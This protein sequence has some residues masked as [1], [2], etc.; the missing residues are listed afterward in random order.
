MLE[1]NFPYFLRM[2]LKTESSDIQNVI[3]KKIRKELVL[4][5][6]FIHFI[7]NI[8]AYIIESKQYILYFSSLEAV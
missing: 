7:D 2:G 8:C 1:K 3:Y 6:D 5:A 4:I